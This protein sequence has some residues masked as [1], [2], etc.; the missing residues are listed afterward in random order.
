MK[1]TL[2]ALSVFIAA[3]AFA[4]SPPE[5]VPQSQTLQQQTIQLVDGNMTVERFRQGQ[6]E[7][8]LIKQRHN[9]PVMIKMVL[10]G[11]AIPRTLWLDAS[12]SS[13][14]L[15][16][17]WLEA[18]L[19][20]GDGI[21]NAG[22]GGGSGEITSTLHAQKSGRFTEGQFLVGVYGKVT[23]FSKDLSS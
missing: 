14:Q 2:L 6:A 13:K 1:K 17:L 3:S 9:W 7:Q 22:H 19:P 4:A 21:T 15:S 16:T 23:D 10:P 11:A 12:A 20:V 18:V 5:Q 8:V